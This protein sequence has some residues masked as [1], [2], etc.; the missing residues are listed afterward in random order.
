MRLLRHTTCTPGVTVVDDGVMV[1]EFRHCPLLKIMR[2][3]YIRV[4]GGEASRPVL[5]LTRHLQ[6]SLP[7]VLKPMAVFAARGA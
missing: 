4:Y 1:S 3:K 6:W 7:A 5:K 2:A